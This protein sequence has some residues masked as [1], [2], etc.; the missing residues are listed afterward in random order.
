M[1]G[2]THTAPPFPTDLPLSLVF[3][4]HRGAHHHHRRLHHHHYRR[5]LLL[6]SC[7]LHVQV[8]ADKRD[9]ASRTRGE[10]EQP[11]PGADLPPSLPPLFFIFI[12]LLSLYLPAP[13]FLFY[14]CKKLPAF[15]SS[16]IYTHSDLCGSPEVA[17]TGVGGNCIKATRVP[18]AT[19]DHRGQRR[20]PRRVPRSR[21]A[22][23]EA[24]SAPAR[25]R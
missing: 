13:F 18:Q 21:H 20:T 1:G 24:A 5:H 15:P 6:S 9:T 17:P 11:A 22:A 12:F 16:N 19:S 25:R 8:R 23:E 14:W 10:S 3:F 7:S 4:F 2:E